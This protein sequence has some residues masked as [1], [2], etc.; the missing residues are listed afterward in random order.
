MKRILSIIFL[1]IPF[2]SFAL[3]NTSLSNVEKKVRETLK[4]TPILAVEESK[5]KGIYIVKT[6]KNI[7]YID[8]N[9]D[10]IIFGRIFDIKGNDIT[11]YHSKTIKTQ[12][13]DLKN[14]YAFIVNQKKFNV[15]LDNITIIYPTD[16]LL[17]DNR[18]KYLLKELT[19]SSKFN[20]FLYIVPASQIV[21]NFISFMICKDINI[22]RAEN[23]IKQ[24]HDFS[25]EDCQKYRNYRDELD[26]VLTTISFDEYLTVIYHGNK[27]ILRNFR[28]I[29]DFIKRVK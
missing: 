10:Y 9:V 16:T 18:I 29:D 20:I 7:F 24:K 23:L 12:K 28:E 15:N 19:K 17:L 22:P 26:E 3:D 8:E 21:D 11:A 2:L 4:N 13:Y 25:Y 6:P 1:L 14:N 27:Y 5:I